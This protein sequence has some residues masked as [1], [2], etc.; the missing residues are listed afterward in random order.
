MERIP[1]LRLRG[2]TPLVFCPAVAVRR[3][4]RITKQWIDSI[5]CEDAAT[6]PFSHVHSE[7]G[8]FINTDVGFTCSYV[9]GIDGSAATQRRFLE[10]MTRGKITRYPWEFSALRAL[11]LARESLISRRVCPEYIKIRARYYI[12]VSR[13]RNLFADRRLALEL[14]ATSQIGNLREELAEFT[15]CPI[16]TER[17]PRSSEYVRNLSDDLGELRAIFARTRARIT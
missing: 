16:L 13:L 11:P 1:P 3:M 10:V 7:V 17:L 12:A 9:R 4:C 5:P 6:P 2:D 8:P 15:P 14:V